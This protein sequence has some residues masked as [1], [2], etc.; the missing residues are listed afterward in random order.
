MRSSIHRLL[1]AILLV[2]FS[3]GVLPK[4]LL[5]DLL[6]SHKDDV[7]HACGK[8]ELVI[9]EKHNHCK[10]LSFEVTAFVSPEPIYVAFAEKEEYNKYVAYYDATEPS[11]EAHYTCSRGPPCA[12]PI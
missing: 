2:I 1:A 4:E 9:T 6:Y 11:T 7:H 10:F 8:G 12:C 3:A 5:H